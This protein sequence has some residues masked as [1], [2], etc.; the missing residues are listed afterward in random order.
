LISNRRIVLSGCSGSGKS[1]LLDALSE[2]G[3]RV[4]PEAGRQIV[5]EQMKAGGSALPWDD[6][7]AFI[8]LTMARAMEQFEDAA[9]GESV[10]IFDRS[11]VD[12]ISHLEYLGSSVPSAM[13]DATEQRRYERRVLM[14]PPWEAIYV[15]EPERNKPFTTALAEYEV[16]VR[17]Y[18][19]LGYEPVLIPPAPV[20]A[21]VDFVERAILRA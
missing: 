21:R 17:T 8:C 19:R 13:A 5:R 1:T 12:L 9:S 7:D 11:V 3:F 2:R 4:V 18:R 14:T 6:V 20:E 16:L 15:D 10:V